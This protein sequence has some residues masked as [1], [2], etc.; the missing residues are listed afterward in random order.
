MEK[1]A[2]LRLNVACLG[3]SAYGLIASLNENTRLCPSNVRASVRD[4]ASALAQKHY[5]LMFESSCKLIK[6]MDK[7]FT[8]KSVIYTKKGFQGELEIGRASCRERV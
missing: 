4:V 1:K 5:E 3:T 7:V 8:K 2:Q 6:A